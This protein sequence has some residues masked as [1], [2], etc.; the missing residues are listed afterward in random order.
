[1]ESVSAQT[2]TI[3]SRGLRSSAATR[4]T[5]VVK[6]D[7]W[8]GRRVF[9]ALLSYKILYFSVICFALWLWPELNKAAYNNC[10]H[11]PRNSAP[12][13]A[14]HFATWDAAHYLFLSEAGYKRGSPSCAF[15]PLWPLMIRAGSYLTGGNHLIAGLLLANIL[16]VAALL[17]FHRLVTLNHGLQAA[18][19]ATVLLLAF[20]GALFFSFAYTESL[21][22]AL[23]TLFFLLLYREKYGWAG[24][25]GFFL[26]LTKAIGIF[27]LFPLLIQLM[28]KRKPWRY[29]LACDGPLL[30][31]LAY[32]A[33]MRAATGNPLE[34]FQAQRFYPNQPSI[35][36]IFDLRAFLD[37]FWMP[38]RLHGMTDSAIDRGLFVLVLAALFLVFRLS[39][40]D[41]AYALPVGVV[42]AMSSWFFSYNRNMMMCFPVF[43]A[44]ALLLMKGSAR[45]AVFWCLIVLMFGIQLWFLKRHL[46]FYWAG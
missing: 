28:A 20:P 1:M 34:G 42:P 23:V 16:S 18:N 2:I 25:V 11:W 46:D 35:A 31:Y 12:T 27:C 17:L 19:F 8:P 22:L 24:F 15:Y 37:A 21:F 26:P 6:P 33:F 13:E 4:D 3:P 5:S 41:F 30:G 43:I 32:F 14:T 36:H 9:Y 39:K 10:I 40:V 45:R 44:L 38:V 7:D 29:Y